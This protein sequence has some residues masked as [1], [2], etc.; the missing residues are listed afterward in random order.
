MNIEEPVFSIIHNHRRSKPPP[1]TEF[2]PLNEI[3]MDQLDS[4]ESV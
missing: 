2:Q 4:L 1:Q 3:E